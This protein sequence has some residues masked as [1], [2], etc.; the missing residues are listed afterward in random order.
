[1]FA[2]WTPVNQDIHKGKDQTIKD[3]LLIKILD[4]GRKHMYSS[5]VCTYLLLFNYVKGY[6]LESEIAIAQN[7]NYRG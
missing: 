1:M 3:N 7:L 6:S 5:H 2:I 4:P